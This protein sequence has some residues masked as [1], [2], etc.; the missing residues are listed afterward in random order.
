MAYRQPLVF[1]DNDTFIIQGFTK[2]EYL[3][4]TKVSNLLTAKFLIF[5]LDHLIVLLV[6]A[7]GFW[8]VLTIF[9]E[10]A[11]LTFKSVFHKALNL[12]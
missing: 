3:V 2:D 12:Y 10:G 6:M 4:R 11:Y 7:E 5:L 8:G 1:N 9:N